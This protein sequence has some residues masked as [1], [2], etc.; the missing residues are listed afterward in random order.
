MKELFN[1]INKVLAI[2][3][4][5]KYNTT[6]LLLEHLSQCY[7][8]ENY[9]VIFMID[10]TINMPYR[11]REHW[12]ENNNKVSDLVSEHISKNIHKDT[13]VL[14]NEYNLGT[15]RTC[16]NLINYAMKL[17]DYVIFLED[18]IILGKDALLFYHQ[19]FLFNQK[20]DK[21]FGV[22]SATMYGQSSESQDNIFTLKKVN[23]IGS[24][25]FGVGKNVW[26]K[27]GHI[28]GNPPH[29]AADFGH[30]CRKDNMHTIFPIVNRSCRIGIHHP[31]SYSGYHHNNID[32]NK[33]QKCS[34]ASDQFL[35]SDLSH[36]NYVSNLK[37]V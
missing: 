12:I 37:F 11:D 7:D 32:Q 1:M 2:Q 22:S 9:S 34:P 25:E 17:S 30:A 10:S 23:W 24:A 6:K 16:H 8:R 36:I 21:M 28:R 18:D 35:T 4:F 19:A 15:M 31:D 29:G 3:C 27:Y 5:V 26:Q 20:D 33:N 14:K 13:I